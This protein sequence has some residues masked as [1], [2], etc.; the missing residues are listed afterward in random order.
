MSLNFKL[1]N[2]SS[3]HDPFSSD[4][5]SGI[6]VNDLVGGNPNAL[7]FNHGFTPAFED[8]FKHSGGTSGSGSTGSTTTTPHTASAGLII[9]L[10]WDASVISTAPPGFMAAVQQ[11]ADML[12]AAIS[13]P[14]TLNFN[15]GWGEIGGTAITQSGVAEGGPNSGVWESMSGLA[16]ALA[17]HSTSATDASVLANLGAQNPNGNGNVAVWSAQEK[18]LGLLSPTDTAIDGEIGFSTDFPS[19]DWVGAALHELAHAMGRTAGYSPYGILDL[20]RYS[21]PGAHTYAGS[22]TQAAYFSVDGGKTNLAKFSNSSDYGDLNIGAND[23]FNAYITPGSSTLTSVDLTTLDAIGFTLAGTT[24]TPP[25]PP[26]LADLTVSSASLTNTT[27]V[28]GANLNLAYLIADIGGAAGASTAQVLID[29]KLVATNTIAALAAGG[30]ASVSDV[31]STAGLAAGAHTITINAN[32]GG[33]VSESN[34]ANNAASLSFTLT[35]P[36]TTAADLIVSS[37]TDKV[38]AATSRRAGS[39]S[40]AFTV[41]NIGNAAAGS[42]YAGIYLDGKAN[43]SLT[44]LISSMAAGGSKTLSGSLSTAGLTHGQHTLTVVADYRN[45]VAESNESNNARSVTF[46]V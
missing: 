31:I 42:E 43:P 20:M 28:Q 22:A 1:N 11:A 17:A 34:T 29:G 44:A 12:M 10:V 23:P 13:D 16:A 5:S 39:V 19:Y 3:A 9:N 25:P 30:N 40:F 14:I 15:V 27:L 41:A 18:A 35:A 24:V 45:N 26:V 21:A 32:S 2:G 37:L 6:T 8:F 7:S 36:P 33:T 46:T 4:K 38:N